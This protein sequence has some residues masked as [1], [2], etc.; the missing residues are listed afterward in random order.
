[1]V[2]DE[3]FEWAAIKV[4][5]NAFTVTAA[6]GH[7]LEGSGVVATATSALFRTRKTAVN[8]FVTSRLG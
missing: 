1:M 8:T 2:V 5:A 6:A 4:G 7:T 3:S